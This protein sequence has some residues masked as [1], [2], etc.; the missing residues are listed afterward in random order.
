MKT[1][2]QD[3]LMPYAVAGI[4]AVGLKYL[5]SRASTEDLTWILTPT[6]H[7]VSWVSGLSFAMDSPAGYINRD[8][9]IAIAPSCSGV[10]FLIIAFAMAFFSFARRLPTTG[11][12]YLWIGAALTGAYTLTLFV[13]TVR[14][15]VSIATISHDL[16]AGW[17]TPERI[18]R[19]EGI[20]IYFLFLCLYYQ[21]IHKI[22][23]VDSRLKR[24]KTGPLF[25]YLSMALLVPVLTGNFHD[26]HSLFME[27]GLTVILSCAGVL[28]LMIGLRRL[29]T[30]LFYRDTG[31]PALP[32]DQG[33]Q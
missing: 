16:H 3:S 4:I 22:T 32:R 28:C 21:G 29:C 17:L 18:H 31:Y 9:G 6:S 33:G 26:H 19:I 24:P 25:W 23:A 7:L 12:T 14:I 8:L 27:H 11:S 20:M 1:N 30:P 5:Y 13:N 10:N 15:C 2:R